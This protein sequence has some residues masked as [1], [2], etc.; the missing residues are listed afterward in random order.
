MEKKMNLK[1]DLTKKQ[2]NLLKQIDIVSEDRDYPPEEIK[3]CVNSISEHIMSQSSK[4]G[5]LSKA[6]FQY[7][8][9]IKTLINENNKWLPNL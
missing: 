9:I 1:K 2:Q 3:R 5:D 8:E 6:L 7:N 4:N